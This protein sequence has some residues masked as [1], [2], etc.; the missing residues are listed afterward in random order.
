MASSTLQYFPGFESGGI[1]SGG[2]RIH[3]VKGGSGPP[4]LLLHGNPQT[5][6]MWHKIAP[7]LAQKFTVVAPD[8]RGYGASDKPFGEPGHSTYS[9]RVMAQDQVALM[10]HLGFEKFY[11]AGHDRGG[12]VAHRLTRDHPERVEKLAVLD[13]CPTADMY[14]QTDMAFATAYFHW[15]FLIQPYD[16]PERLIGSDAEY[17]IRAAMRKYSSKQDVIPE[18][19]MNQYVEAF[20]NPDTIH[21]LCEDYRASATIDLDHDRADDEFKISCPLLVIWG[22]QGVVGT[23]FDPIALWSARAEQVIGKSLPCG[24]FIPEEMPEETL[25]ALGEFFGSE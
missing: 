4:L 14:A 1:D 20:C 17:F 6:L 13:I 12:R 18:S 10:T 24:H 8:L 16:M 22:E 2:V 23:Q 9:K 5:H 7:R 19:I 15:F 25:A 11:A 3:Y 21:A